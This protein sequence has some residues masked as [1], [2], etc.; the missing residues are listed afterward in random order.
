MTYQAIA[1]AFVCWFLW[2]RRDEAVALF[3]PV[4]GMLPVL[5]GYEEWLL[6]TLGSGGFWV[7]W[8]ANRDL[9]VKRNLY[10]LKPA[11]RERAFPGSFVQ[12][13]CSHCSIELAPRFVSCPACSKLVQS[14]QL[15]VL[16]STAVAA[17]AAGRKTEALLSLREMLALLPEDSGQKK[18]I[19]RQVESLSRETDEVATNTL[20]FDFKTAGS[21]VAVLGLV[22]WKLKTLL[23]LAAANLKTL[24]VALKSG[25]TLVS[26]LASFL[27]LW[28]HMSWQ[29]ALGLIAAIYVHEIGHVVALRRLKIPAT[30]PMFVPGLGAFV[31]FKQYPASPRD[32]A[33]VGLAGPIWGLG[34]TAFLLLIFFATG[35]TTVGRIMLWSV[36]INLFN[37]LPIGPLDGGRGFSAIGRRDRAIITAV[38]F[39][40]GVVTNSF[41]LLLLAVV[42]LFRVVFGPWPVVSDRKA[43]WQ[44]IGLVICFGLIGA[45][46]VPTSLESRS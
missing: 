2:G 37:L 18:R 28:S 34:A 24:V 19:G 39:A 23:F 45:I 15:K 13:T 7:A 4:I 22:L 29:L 42:A 14:D 25:T 35:A 27:L 17:F 10:F 3:E 21:F 26:M 43:F 36:W 16:R 46:E 32:N 31:R 6:L 40:S 38:L 5:A 12:A 8:G 33:L 20:R 9:A 11:D 1:I 41:L 30:A 44:L